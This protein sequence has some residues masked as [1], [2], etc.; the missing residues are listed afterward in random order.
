MQKL[1][2]V[3]F[4]KTSSL[5]QK[6][7]RGWRDLQT[8]F[9]HSTFASAT[10]SAFHDSFCY[11]PSYYCPSDCLFYN[12]LFNGAS[13]CRFFYCP[14]YCSSLNCPFYYSS[15]NCPFYYSSLNSTSYC[16]FFYSS[17]DGCSFNSSS[18]SCSFYSPS[19]CGSSC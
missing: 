8:S 1:M 17:F 9:L 19:G 15:L 14:F 6:K 5:L 2:G 13:D 3:Y 18:G 7:S 4:A 10:A 11:S 16:S 12:G